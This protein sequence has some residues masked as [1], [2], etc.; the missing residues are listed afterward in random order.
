MALLNQRKFTLKSLIGDFDKPKIVWQRITGKNNFS[1]DDKGIFILDSSCLLTDFG[2]YASYLLAVLNSDLIYFWMCKNIHL[3]G[4]KG[5]L[6]SNQYVEK[7][8]VPRNIS[9]KLIEQMET[10]INSGE[11]VDRENLETLIF[12]LYNL[13]QAE[14]NHVKTM[15]EER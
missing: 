6:L 8:P 7:I 1:F 12:S 9:D 2:K 11:N 4:A 14:I 15:I 5:F 3:L 10:L 13:N